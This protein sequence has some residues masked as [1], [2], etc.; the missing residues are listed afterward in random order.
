MASVSTSY[1]RYD[2]SVEHKEEKED[3]SIAG[4]NELIQ[5]TQT[6][7][8][9]RYRHA[10]RF[11]H[12]KSHGIIKADLKVDAGLPPELSQGLFS[13]ARTYPTIVRFSTAPATSWQTASP[14]RRAWP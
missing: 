8:N 9:E 10:V 7:L 3:E 14:R 12:S 4:L 1:V 6:I 11:V 13:V 2:D 5:K